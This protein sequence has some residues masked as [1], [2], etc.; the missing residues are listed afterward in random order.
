MIEGDETVGDRARDDRFERGGGASCHSEQ[1]GSL[2]RRDRAVEKGERGLRQ[3]FVAAPEGGTPV[4]G[5]RV[6]AVPRA[7]GGGDLLDLS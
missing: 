4:V 2:G 6:D 7:R 5:H 3:E 1:P